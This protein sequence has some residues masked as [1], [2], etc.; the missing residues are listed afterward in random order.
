MK[1][2]IRRA[3]H[4]RKGSSW[5]EA[6]GFSLFWR[7][8]AGLDPRVVGKAKMSSAGRP[9]YLQSAAKQASVANKC[10]RP[11]RVFDALI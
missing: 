9:G 6:A 7:R 10:Q 5:K 8:R 11:F 2:R 4:Q 1:T 3:F